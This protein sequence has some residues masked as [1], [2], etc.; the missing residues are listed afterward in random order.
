MVGIYFYM[1]TKDGNIDDCETA[2]IYG[3]FSSNSEIIASAAE[4][5][6]VVKDTQ[7]TVSN[8]LDIENCFTLPS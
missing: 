7:S 4:N 6:K 2:A 8:L 5:T 1:K 3:G